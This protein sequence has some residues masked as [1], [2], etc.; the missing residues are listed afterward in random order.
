VWEVTRVCVDRSVAPEIR[1]TIFPELLCGINE[2]FMLHGIVAMTGVTR[3]HLLEHFCRTGVTWLGPSQVIEG[4]QESAFYV[5]T[6]HIRPV[7][8]CARYGLPER[9]LVLPEA[10]QRRIA[11]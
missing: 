9:V 8:H 3:P 4:E 1:K 10:P 2:Y 5:P 6:Q 7:H 11:A